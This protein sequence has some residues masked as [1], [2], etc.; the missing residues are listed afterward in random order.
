MC[1]SAQE[2]KDFPAMVKEV[3]W[4]WRTAYNTAVQGCSEWTD[5]EEQLAE[6]FDLSRAVIYLTSRGVFL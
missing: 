3:S 5:S 4:L 1:E 6:L 2:K